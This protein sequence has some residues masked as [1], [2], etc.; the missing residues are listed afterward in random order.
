MSTD[1][2]PSW[3]AALALATLVSAMAAC[4]GVPGVRNRIA[5]G[6]GA[7][8]ERLSAPVAPSNA[9]LRVD[10]EFGR[11]AGRVM[12]GPVETRI[13]CPK[14][15]IER[16]LESSGFVGGPYVEDPPEIEVSL[17]FDPNRRP[18][19]SRCGSG[20]GAQFNPADV[21]FATGEIGA[22]VDI[23]IRDAQRGDRS[24]SGSGS[25]AGVDCDAGQFMSDAQAQFLDRITQRISLAS[26]AALESALMGRPEVV[27]L[28]PSRLTL[29]SP[30]AQQP[31][32]PPPPGES[33]SK[34][35]SS[36]PGAP[37]SRRAALPDPGV[38]GRYTALVIG[39]DRYIHLPDL[40]NAVHDARSVGRLLRDEYGFEVVELANPTRAEILQTLTALRRRLEQQDNLLIYY[41]G[42]G[43]LDADADEGY[44]LPVDADRE[45]PTYWVSNDTIT[46]QLRALRAKHVMVVA[47]S[48]YS[49]KL[50]RGIDIGIRPSDYYERMAARRTRVVISSGGLEPVSDSGGTRGHSVF[51]SAFLEA[52]RGNETV[53][54][55]SAVFSRVRR[56]VMTNADQIPEYSDIRKAGHD[57]GDFL[58]VPRR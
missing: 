14:R 38:F 28:A 58:F 48:C 34:S 2:S 36:S 52:L 25:V 21:S 3:L 32:P 44:W 55:G 54:D 35:S 46:A 39:I 50:T 33:V 45:D 18:Q 51:A 8:T 10:C 27:A 5:P 57:G 31:V 6:V 13:E 17:R 1:R 37:P 16:Y 30:P 24:I 29:V 47:D 40:R 7:P 4:V 12:F 26:R 20:G 56:P 23:R 41:A 9:E 43:W 49:G 42:H 53:I 15:D 19:M 11:I 22:L